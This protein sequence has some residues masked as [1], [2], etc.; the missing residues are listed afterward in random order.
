MFFHKMQVMYAS[1]RVI[2]HLVTEQEEMASKLLQVY[3]T[4][5]NTENGPMDDRRNR[6]GKGGGNGLK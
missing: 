2:K 1:L 3:V 4:I 5:D 6:W